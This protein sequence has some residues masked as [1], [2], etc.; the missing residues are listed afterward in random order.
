MLSIAALLEILYLIVPA[1]YLKDDTSAVGTTGA[2]GWGTGE[3][4]TGKGPTGGELLAPPQATTN[5]QRRHQ[6]VLRS[7]IFI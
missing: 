5:P 6:R 4:G 2:A 7:G 1:A 3:A